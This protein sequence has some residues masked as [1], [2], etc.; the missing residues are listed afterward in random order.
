MQGRDSTGAKKKNLEEMIAE[1]K[2]SAGHME[3][4]EV[5]S[6]AERFAAKSLPKTEAQKAFAAVLALP[7]ISSVRKIDKLVKETKVCAFH[8]DGPTNAEVVGAAALLA[9]D[10]GAGTGGTG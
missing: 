9:E 4:L 3:I 6:A 1:A 10:G 5:T 8:G 2:E 7:K